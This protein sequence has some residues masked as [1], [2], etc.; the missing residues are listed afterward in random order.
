MKRGAISAE[1]NLTEKRARMRSEKRVTYR[2]ETMPSTSS[3][4]SK[5]DNLVR[6]MEIMMERINLTDRV[7][8]RENQPRPQNQKQN[9]R[10]NPP[11]IKKREQR[12][13]KHKIIPPFQENYADDEGEIVEEVE[14]NQINLMN[15]ISVTVLF[16]ILVTN[17]III[18]FFF[19]SIV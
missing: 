14:D 18:N 1:A 4:D 16:S 10:I 3:S 11:Q 19:L 6:A 9:V 8:P 12:E 5:I 7:A 13:P 15:K 17:I 2:D